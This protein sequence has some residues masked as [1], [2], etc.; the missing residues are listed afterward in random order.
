MQNRIASLWRL[1][2]G[3]FNKEL[4]NRTFLFQFFHKLDSKRVLEGGPWTYDNYLLILHQLVAGEIPTSIALNF[5]DF[6][7][8]IHDLHIGFMSVAIGTKIGNFISSFLDYNDSNNS[9]IWRNYMRIRVRLDV[10]KPLKCYKKIRRLNGDC[11]I[12]NLK[13]ERLGIFCFICGLLG[14]SDKFCEQA[15]TD[16]PDEVPREW[17]TWLRANTR[18]T[19]GG[20]SGDK[21]LRSED[22]SPMGVSIISGGSHAQ[23]S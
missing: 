4:S 3:I 15:F 11:A 16:K 1:V 14:D 23:S 19:D 20:S 13:Y 17:G 18:Q 5:V 10:R 9:S 7:V 8:Q 22:G 6:W 2:K 21:W 12:L